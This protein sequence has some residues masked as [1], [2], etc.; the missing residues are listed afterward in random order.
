MPASTPTQ[1]MGEGMPPQ[2]ANRLGGEP[3]V[4]TAAG[5]TQGT[6]AILKSR[7][8][9]IS[10]GASATG[11]IPPTSALICE[12]YYLFCS[13]ATSAV[14]YCP[15][16]HTLNGTLNGSLTIAQNKAA[17]VWQYKKG[18]WASVLTA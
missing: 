14:F 2:L 13:T 5:T 17:I 3:N 10:T 8:T 7:N 1:L 11:V 12:D 6:A 15:S 16:G 4:L 18:F 9:E